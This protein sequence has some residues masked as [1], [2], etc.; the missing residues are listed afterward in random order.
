MT[1]RGKILIDE[2][3]KLVQRKKR[4]AIEGDIEKQYD[5]HAMMTNFVRSECKANFRILHDI[6]KDNEWY[7]KVTLRES[8]NVN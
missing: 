6:V 8:S 4:A 3:E 1:I 2:C 7:R 5:L